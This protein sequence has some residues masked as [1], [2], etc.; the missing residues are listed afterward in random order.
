MLSLLHRY[1]EN[2]DYQLM[3][4]NWLLR[5]K[6]LKEAFNVIQSVLKK[7]ADNIDAKLT[8]LDYYTEIGNNIKRNGIINQLLSSTEV[9]EI[10]K[11]QLLALK[12]QDS[13]KRIIKIQSKF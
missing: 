13:K 5:Y 10:K 4:A 6:R 7:Y 8:L 12:V 1:P 9:D 3:N 2:L 11:A